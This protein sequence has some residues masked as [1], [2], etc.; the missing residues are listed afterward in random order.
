MKIMHWMNL[1]S[2]VKGRQFPMKFA[3]SIHFYS[4][5]LWMKYIKYETFEFPS[6]LWHF[7]DLVSLIS[8]AHN[9]IIESTVMQEMARK[10]AHKSLQTNCIVYVE[11]SIKC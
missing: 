4:C 2:P 10:S 9:F 7:A 3:I 5:E 11:E 1:I 8:F 6:S